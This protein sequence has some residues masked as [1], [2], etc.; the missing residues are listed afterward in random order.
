MLNYLHIENI[1]VIE[2]S[3]LEVSGGFSCLTGE[4][5]AGKSIIIDAINAVLGA[6]TSK[7]LI[8]S[9][10]DKAQVIAEFSDIGDT[11]AAV[12]NENG[13]SLDENGTLILQRTLSTDGR[14]SFRINSQPATAAVLKEVGKYL[15]NIHGQHDNQSLLDPDKHCGFIDRLA[16]NDLLIDEYYTEFKTLNACRRELKALEIDEE[17]KARRIDLL[18]YQINELE[19]ADIKVGELDELKEKIKL[20]RDF[21][22]IS[23]ALG[24]AYACISGDENP[25]AAEL[26]KNALKS[27]ASLEYKPA[28]DLVPKLTETVENLNDIGEELRNTIA[29]NSDNEYNI[30]DIENRLDLIGRLMMKYGGSEEKMLEFLDNAKK[31]LSD[32]TFADERAEELEQQLLQSQERLI[33][34]AERLSLSRKAAAERF[35]AQVCEILRELNMPQVT[36]TVSITEGRYTKSGRDVVEFMM[37]PNAGEDVKPL[38]RTASGGELSRVMLAIKSVLSDKDDVN[39]LVF[40]EIDTGISGRAATKVAAQLKKVARFRQVICVTH[41]AQ[42]AACA[43]NH[44][45]IE[46][47]VREDRTYTTV[48]TLGYDERIREI[49]RIMSGSDMTEIM[50]SSAKELLDR[51]L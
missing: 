2:H 32:I 38:S 8:R 36:F 10:C 22:K 19:T 46:K 4:T 43:D 31:Q 26:L 30:D 39:T 13:Y 47:S 25:G 27:L 41:L 1:A 6:R 29:Q 14:S 15:I 5:G 34:K 16:E 37:S 12:L 50:F 3:E 17:E 45:L 23:K 24:S 18:K 40:D 9:G 33:E 44:L 20:C 51:S 35:S 21:E 11:A 7:E 48:K 28:A 42:I 49:A